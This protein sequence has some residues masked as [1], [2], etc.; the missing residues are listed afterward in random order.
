MVDKEL[1]TKCSIIQIYY[2]LLM[3]S[4]DSLKFILKAAKNRRDPGLKSPVEHRTDR[5]ENIIF[6][7]DGCG[8]T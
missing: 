3:R 6:L 7:F 2:D 5:N 4:S 8:D 1:T